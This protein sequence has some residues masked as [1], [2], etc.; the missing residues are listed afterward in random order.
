[1]WTCPDKKM[2]ASISLAVPHYSEPLESHYAF[3]SIHRGWSVSLF[4]S[5]HLHFPMVV[6]GKNMYKSQN[7]Y[8]S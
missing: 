2:S 8:V 4:I 1:M 3:S 5:L 6:V 7:I